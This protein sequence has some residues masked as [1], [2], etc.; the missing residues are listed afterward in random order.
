MESKISP[1]VDIS[2]QIHKIVIKIKNNLLDNVFEDLKKID[3]VNRNNHSKIENIYCMLFQK[4]KSISDLISIKHKAENIG[5]I[6]G[7]AFLSTFIKCICNLC[8]NEDEFNFCRKSCYKTLDEIKEKGYMLKQRMYSPIIDLFYRFNE[9][10]RIID[11]YSECYELG[12]CLKMDDIIKVLVQVLINNAKV[13]RILKNSKFIEPLDKE[14][15]LMEISNKYQAKIHKCNI[16]G[17]Y[18]TEYGKELSIIDLSDEEH[19]SILSRIENIF[20]NKKELIKLKKW[21]DKKEENSIVIDGANVGYY[22]M[23]PDKGGNLNYNQIEIIG[24]YY[25]KNGK[26]IIIFLH[27]RHINK[28]CLSDIN[29]DLIKKWRREN[30]LYVTPWKENDD[31]YWLYS[32]FYIKKSKIVTNDE[33]RDHHFNTLSSTKEF[34]HWKNLHQIKYDLKYSLKIFEPRLLSDSIQKIDEILYIPV[35][36]NSKTLWYSLEFST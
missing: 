1:R 9:Y 27:K 10:I 11:I 25:R 6:R 28:S 2:K 35:K 31:L 19:S 20:L 15:I 24:N 22:N 8:R 32:S 3:V 7:E 34:P 17:N 16:I 33:M 18:C 29:N 36:K 21:L 13:D 5:T 4:M 14:E 26:K 23:R 12:I 30:E